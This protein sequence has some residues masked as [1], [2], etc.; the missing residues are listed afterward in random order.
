MWYKS[1]VPL[2]LGFFFI[3]IPGAKGQ[4]GNMPQKDLIRAGTIAIQQ[5]TRI[6]TLLQRHIRHNQNKRGIDGYRIQIFFNSGPQAR[7]Q[8]I[9][10]KADFLSSYPNLPAYVLY[11]SP[12]YKVRIGDFPTKNK[13]LRVYYQVRKKYR[14]AYIVKDIIKF[15]VLY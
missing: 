5:D 4:D 15:P 12:F 1:L 14:T 9:R 2:F 13:A 11:Q 10:I 3:I 7:E 6:S 8:A